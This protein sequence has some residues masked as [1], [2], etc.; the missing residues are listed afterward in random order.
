MSMHARIRT[1]A[2]LGAALIICSAPVSAGTLFVAADVE[3]FTFPVG[4][5]VGADRLGKLTTSGATIT[6]I[7][8][9]VTDFLINGMADADGK[10]LAGTP[11]ANAL[12]TVGFDGTLISTIAAPGIPNSGCCNEEMLFVP[13][14]VGADKFYHAHYQDVIREIDPITG[15]Q[16]A[17]FNQA[18]VVGMAL[19]NGEIWISKWAGQ[20][21]GIWDPDT[22]IFTPEFDLVGLG[23][24]GALAWDPLDMV[25]WVGSQGGFVTPFDLTGAQLGTSVQPFGNISQTIDGATFLGEVT[26]VQVPAPGT[27]ALAGLGVLW[28]GLRRRRPA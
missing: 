28:L 20:E 15:V 26:Q 17:V 25:L 6:N 3:D 1:F 13:Q 11:Q 21:I 2:V 12:N 24:A 7:E 18:D 16:I 14:A 5:T 4:T 9:I 23:N 19:I 22:N 27:L 8:I 10:L